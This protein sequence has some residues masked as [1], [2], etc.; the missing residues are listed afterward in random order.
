MERLSIPDL[1]YHQVPWGRKEK[2]EGDCTV[3][4]KQKGKPQQSRG[5]NR[6]NQSVLNKHKRH[7]RKTRHWCDFDEKDKKLMRKEQ[8]IKNPT[9]LVK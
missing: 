4:P 9:S 5:C 1:S 3:I 6:V 7:N 8:L 2:V